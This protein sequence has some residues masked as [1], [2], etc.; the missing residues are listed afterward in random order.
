MTER[1][2]TNTESHEN[3]ELLELRD[4]LNSV[5]SKFEIEESDDWLK[6]NYEWSQL[7]LSLDK[8]NVLPVAKLT[9][10]VLDYY[11]KE[12][13]DTWSQFEIKESNLWW[14]YFDIHIDDNTDW[15]VSYL[16][17]VLSWWTTN[18]VREEIFR[19]KAGINSED[20]NSVT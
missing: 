8:E 18:V 10:W 5:D 14:K 9:S 12:H 11:E 15:I 16:K 4:E 13:S 1:I 2:E 17:S 19:E 20:L 3:Q 7:W 6:L